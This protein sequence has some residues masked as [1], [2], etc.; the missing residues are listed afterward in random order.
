MILEEGNYIYMIFYFLHIL[1]VDYSQY[2]SIFLFVMYFYLI[3]S[4]LLPT[5]HDFGSWKLHNYIQYFIFYTY[6][7]TIS[8][9]HL[10]ELP[11][12]STL[13]FNFS[14]SNE[15]KC[16][17][18]VPADAIFVLCITVD[19]SLISTIYPQTLYSKLLIIVRSIFFVENCILASIEYQV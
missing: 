3:L 14:C 19:F 9:K 16:N 13:D 18:T 4:F 17:V 12:N 8:Y 11:F 2:A 6:S 5:N 10:V 7:Q 1:T 15:D